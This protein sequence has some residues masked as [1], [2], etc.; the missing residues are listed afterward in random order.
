MNP[1]KAGIPLVCE[2]VTFAAYLLAQ[3]KRSPRLDDRDKK[4]CELAQGKLEE[5]EKVL[6]G[7]D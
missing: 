6:Y 7:R 4:S 1:P 5:A 3:L 2:A